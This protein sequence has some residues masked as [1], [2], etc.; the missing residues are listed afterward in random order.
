MIED[1]VDSD[2]LAQALSRLPKLRWIVF[3]D[4]RELARE[5]ESYVDVCERIFGNGLEPRG[6]SFSYHTYQ[7]F[8]LLLDLIAHC[9][10]ANITSLSIGRHLY[11]SF[12]EFWRRRNPD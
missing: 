6:L 2:L 9:P 4:F 10:K 11:E 1:G 5:G 12:E 3:T 8:T 7:E